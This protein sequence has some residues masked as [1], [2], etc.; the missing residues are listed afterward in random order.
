MY[1]S[2]CLLLVCFVSFVVT[3]DPSPT[4]AACDK[5]CRFRSVFA[6]QYVVT[7]WASCM[8]T[9]QP[10]CLFC[11]GLSG[12]CNGREAVEPCTRY[13]VQ[14]RYKIGICLPNCDQFICDGSN[15]STDATTWEDFATD[16][17]YWCD[18]I[19]S[20]TE[21]EQNRK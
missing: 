4:Y 20:S 5:K 19:I 1:R 18:D 10:D 21:I 12:Q 11:T 9:Q 8:Q 14:N 2:L 15:F 6:L 17:T 16:G 13:L 7:P 3:Y